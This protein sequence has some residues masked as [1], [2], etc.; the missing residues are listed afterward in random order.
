MK[1]KRLRHRD[2]SGYWCYLPCDGDRGGL[3]SEGGLSLRES[4]VCSKFRPCSYGC[5][6]CFVLSWDF[7]RYC[8]N[9]G[10]RTWGSGSVGI[11]ASA[12]TSVWSWVTLGMLVWCVWVPQSCLTLC[13]PTD[14]GPP[15]F[16]VHR[17]LQAR[18]L[19][20]IDIPFSRGSSQPR[21]QTRVSDIASRFFNVW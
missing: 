6:V 10:R 9:R 8:L 2:K 11:R 3:P 15:G 12:P 4:K 17:I 21:D 20:W 19:E 18:I 1:I 5:W 16:S 13:N 7:E 14:C